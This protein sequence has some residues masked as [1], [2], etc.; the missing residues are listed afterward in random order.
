MKVTPLLLMAFLA[1]LG[2][3]RM[4]LA[5]AVSTPSPSASPV[6]PSSPVSW[7]PGETKGQKD[8][9]M[10]WW[11]KAKFGMFIHWGLYC[12]PAD[13]EW[14]M[15]NKK[16]PYAE[17][18]QLA[19]EFNPSK[20][21]A[22]SWM[23]LAREAGMN[24][25]VITT[26]H[27]DGFALFK[28][29][30]SPYNV[31]D[32]TP[33][34]RDVVRELSEAAPRHGITFCTYYSFLAD[35]GH[36]GGQAGCPHWDPGYQDGDRRA[37]VTN[38]AIAQVRE[39]LSNYGR[40]GV[41]WFDTDGSRDITPAE[42][43]AVIDVLKTQPQ[44]IVDPRVPGVKGDYDTVE[45]H[46][47]SKRPKSDYWELCT[48]VNGA[49]G[50]KATPA[51]PLNK[52]LPYLITAWGMGGNVLLNVGPTREGI[53]PDDS[54]ERLRQIGYWLKV[55]GESIYGS[56]AGPFDWLPWG[57]A[58]RKGETLYLQ[59]FQ[60]P[61]DGILRVP[62]ANKPLKAWLLADPAKKTLP[63]ERSGDRIVIHLPEKAPDPVV[64][65]IALQVEG[66]PVNTYT[67]LSLNKPVS[68]TSAPD[69]AKAITD[70]DDNSRWKNTEGTA[71]FTIDLGHPETF[72]TVR[73]CPR[74][75]VANV[76]LEVRESGSWRTLLENARLHRDVNVLTFPA[77][78]GDALR[79]SFSGNEKASEFSDFQLYPAL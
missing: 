74:D 57:T 30:A 43:A 8:A 59:V 16:V 58:T 32:A 38:V 68:A 31:A 39:L 61:S 73:V 60:W 3:S 27:H 11:T 10:A 15:R 40:I 72:T 45:A 26:K 29:R 79:L 66:E 55:N 78:T 67:S 13:G 35:W 75:R 69:S 18:S 56:T 47:P 22:D 9:R 6:P 76:R 62:L 1:T 51:T 36:P 50:Y 24:Y 37:Y 23:N 34:K 44:L 12:I 64:G 49:W 52:L 17:Y 63:M 70:D 53:I 5:Q 71:S 7:L 42:D 41:L 20:F 65:V 2:S 21:D 19:K 46:M 54:A 28:S 4:S 25:V 33:F 14:H 48:T 77:T